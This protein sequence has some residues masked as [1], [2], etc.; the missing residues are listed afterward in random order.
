MVTGPVLPDRFEVVALADRLA[1]GAVQAPAQGARLAELAA[2]LRLRLF[3]TR[4]GEGDGREAAALLERA[5]E[6][7][8]GCE[9]WLER[10]RLLGELARDPVVTAREAAPAMTRWPD[11]GCQ[12]RTDA[13]LEEI[14]PYVARS[15][16]RR[17]AAVAAAAATGSAAAAEPEQVVASPEA[18]ARGPAVLQA[19]ESYGDKESARIVLRLNHAAAFE[20]GGGSGRQGW[21]GLPRVRRSGPHP[22]GQSQA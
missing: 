10:A 6:G 14:G 7:E 16:A 13:L 20:V 18:A 1:V 2:R 5:A 12:A 21:G 3:R 8:G 15:G 22:S 17:S 11:P 4:H 19:I 9:R